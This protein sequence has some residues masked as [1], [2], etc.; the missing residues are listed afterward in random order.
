M[1]KPP[2]ANDSASPLDCALRQAWDE[3]FTGAGSASK[4]E[5]LLDFPNEF[6]DQEW[7]W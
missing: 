4:D 6:D 7:Q 3:A 5:L 1:K 2:A